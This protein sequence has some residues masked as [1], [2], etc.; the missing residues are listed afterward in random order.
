M[1]YLLAGFT[2]ETAMRNLIIAALALLTCPLAAAQAAP[3]TPVLPL[4]LIVGG[5]PGNPG[6][7]PLRTLSGPLAGELGQPVV[8]EN[9]PGAAGTVGLAAVARAKADGNVLGLIALQT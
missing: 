5:P 9:K 1:M 8:V 4:V 6:D 7:L 2:Q 3:G